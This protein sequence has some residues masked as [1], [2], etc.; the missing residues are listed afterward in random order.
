MSQMTG[1]LGNNHGE[2]KSKT[3]LSVFWCRKL[4]WGFTSS[5]TGTS[6]LDSFWPARPNRTQVTSYLPLICRRSRSSFFTKIFW[7]PRTFFHYLS[8]C[9]AGMAGTCHPLS[10]SLAVLWLCCLPGWPQAVLL[11]LSTSCVDE[12][13]H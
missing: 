4:K 12:I 2:Y 5:R 13:R 7:D 10:F 11:S 9:I 1:P 8:H 3:F 6:A